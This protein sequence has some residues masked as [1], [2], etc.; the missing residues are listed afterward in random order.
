MCIVDSLQC[1][2]MSGTWAP[3]RRMAVVWA[4]PSDRR[5]SA[6]HLSVPQPCPQLRAAPAALTE[7]KG[8]LAICY[9]CFPPSLTLGGPTRWSSERTKDGPLLASRFP[10]KLHGKMAGPAP[11]PAL[12]THRTRPPAQCQVPVL[13]ER[14]EWG[15]G[16][17]P[18]PSPQGRTHRGSGHTLAPERGTG[19]GGQS[20]GSTWHQVS[21]PTA[22]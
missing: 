11:P 3:R 21:P 2:A 17:C 19:L 5:F 9:I 20:R 18:P 8:A 15:G 1:R 4:T 10:Q 16:T 12:F 7:A 6:T 22:D 14:G 13:E